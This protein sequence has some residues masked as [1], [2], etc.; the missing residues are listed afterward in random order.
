M[1]ELKKPNLNPV[2]FALDFN[3][4]REVCEIRFDFGFRGK[5]YN[6]FEIAKKPADYLPL[7]Q[8]ILEIEGQQTILIKT[9]AAPRKEAEK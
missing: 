2:E 6:R 5:K 4:K 7:I 8:A 1:E 9:P 3:G